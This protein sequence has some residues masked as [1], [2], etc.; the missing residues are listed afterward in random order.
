MVGQ[1]ASCPHHGQS[2]SKAE[3]TVKEDKKIL[4]KYKKACSDGFL[5]LLRII[6]LHLANCAECSGCKPAPICIESVPQ[7]MSRNYKQL[8]SDFSTN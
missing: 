5:A 3:S 8:A 6:F 2:H 1:K 4:F 7:G